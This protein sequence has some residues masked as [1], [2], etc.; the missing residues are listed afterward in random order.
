MNKPEFDY[1][2]LRGR[3]VE[4]FGSQKNFSSKIHISAGTLSQKLTGLK[5]FT[6]VEIFRIASALDIENADISSYFFALK[7]KKS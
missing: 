1:G 6:Q 5:C 4:K 2:K 7:V 3:I